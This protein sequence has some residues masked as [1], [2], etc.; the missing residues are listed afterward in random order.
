MKKGKESRGN[1]FMNTKN[2]AGIEEIK[3]KGNWFPLP[4]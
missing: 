4:R 3:L 1:T 2:E